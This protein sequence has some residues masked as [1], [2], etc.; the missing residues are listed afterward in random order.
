MQVVFVI[1]R[2]LKGHINNKKRA[3]FGAVTTLTLGSASQSWLFVF[4]N[5][6]CNR[7]EK[8]STAGQLLDLETKF[9]RHS[10]DDWKD[11]LGCERR[12]DVCGREKIGQRSSRREESTAKEQLLIQS[13]TGTIYCGCQAV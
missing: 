13:K 6:N 10:K 2:A 11:D 3:I 4:T 8:Q 5:F 1:G 12:S 9:E 7:I